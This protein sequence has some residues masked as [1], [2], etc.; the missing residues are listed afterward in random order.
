M[1]NLQRKPRKKYG[2]RNAQTTSPTSEIQTMLWK[3]QSHRF[4]GTNPATL[5]KK[6]D[7]MG[8][9]VSDTLDEASTQLTGHTNWEWI[10]V[11]DVLPINR[12]PE[13]DSVVIFLKDPVPKETTEEVIRLDLGKMLLTTDCL[14]EVAEELDY[15]MADNLKEM[16]DELT[17]LAINKLDGDDD[18]H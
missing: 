17:T 9:Y 5:I 8:K 10:E 11:D 6:G 18:D 3:N 16:L 13:I 4:N 14:K 2:A 7:T 15:E 1:K 12:R